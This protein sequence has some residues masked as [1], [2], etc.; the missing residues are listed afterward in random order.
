MPV[1]RK[2]RRVLR[3]EKAAIDQRIVIENGSPEGGQ[4]IPG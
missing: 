2:E 4:S 1:A 3:D